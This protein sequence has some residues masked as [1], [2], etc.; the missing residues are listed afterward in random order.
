MSHIAATPQRLRRAFHSG[1]AL[2]GLYSG[3]FLFGASRTAR[4]A[5]NRLTARRHCN[6]WLSKWERHER[7]AA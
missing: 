5:S 2:P 3:R 1:A 4:I 7:M 6:G